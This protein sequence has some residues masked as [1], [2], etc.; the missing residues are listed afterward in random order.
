MDLAGSEKWNTNFKLGAKRTKELTHINKSLSAL[1]N[2]ISALVAK[3]RGHI[4]YRNSKLTRLLQVCVCVSVCCLRSVA[5]ALTSPHRT[6]QHQDSLGGNTRT[7][8]VAAL[9]PMYA[10]QE[11]SI[12]T[13]Q[14]ADRAR[15][16]QMRVRR[17]EV[18]DDAVLLTR[19]Q[20]EITR[21]R[22]ILSADDNA[23]RYTHTCFRSSLSPSC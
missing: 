12:S 6:Q 9:S 7:T 15:R 20:R 22:S 16:V 4:P 21:L 23:T 10:S 5:T 8:V 3:K 14:F 2:C 19:A 1:G 13:M 18:V 17:N 11:E